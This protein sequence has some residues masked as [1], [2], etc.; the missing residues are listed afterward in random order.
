MTVKFRTKAGLAA[1]GLAVL[2]GGAVTASSMMDATWLKTR[3]IQ[4]A[5]QKTGRQL[6][7]RTLHVWLLP[8]PWMQAEGVSLAGRPGDTAAQ[9]FTAKEIR[10][11]LSL[12]ALF[13]HKIVLDDVY[14]MHPSLSL[15]HQKGSPANW[16]FEPAPVSTSAGGPSSGPHAT[17]NVALSTLHVENGHLVWDDEVSHLSGETDLDRAD[18]S[19]LTGSSVSSHIRGHHDSGAFDLTTTTGAWFPG[20][21]SSW[22]LHILAK[23]SEDK[24]QSGEVRVDGM[25]SGA[26]RDPSWDLQITG[27]IHH[28]TDLEAVFPKAGLP[29]ADDVSLQAAIA[30][31]PH[32]PQIRMLHLHAGDTDLHQLLRGLHADT[33][34]MDA[35]QPGDPLTVSLDGGLNGQPLVLRGTFGTADQTVQAARSG[36]SASLP[37]HLT[38]AD[39]PSSVSVAGT[40]GGQKSDLEIHGALPSFSSDPELPAA[41]GLKV[42]GHVSGQMPFSLFTQQDP[43]VWIRAVQGTLDVSAARV[44]WRSVAWTD[45]SAHI[46]SDGGK[47]TADPIRAKGTGPTAGMPQAG[48][49]TYD[50]SGD[51]PRIS[52]TAAPVVLPAEI[53]ENIAGIPALASGSLQFVGSVATDGDDMAAWKRSAGGH[54]GVSMVG[55]RVSGQ[56]LSAIIG[57]SVPMRGTLGL[58]CFGV[59][60]NIAD[61]R[62][63]LDRLGLEADQLSLSGHGSVGLSSG[64]LDLHLTPYIGF[65]GAGASSPVGVG[66]TI[67][68]PQPHLEPGSDGR[69]ALQI[70]G[71]APQGD[72]CPDLLSASREGTGGPAAAP[73]AEGKMHG[74]MNMLRGLIR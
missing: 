6:Q 16:E 57:R 72:P 64:A 51:T 44:T 34:T 7:I 54:L 42:D 71:N 52:V 15:E 66:G 53:V 4:A 61:N 69:F 46:V 38:L 48:H 8:Y 25:L 58:R 67:S 56:A 1:G 33:V 28:L 68:S 3:L 47:L 32:A 70:G 59:H 45:A 73:P 12:S 41:Q 10:G 17:W 60:M 62:A 50:V 9:M 36:V 63:A 31:T 23:L 11:R 18:I 13:S 2:L 74:L 27:N 30:G 29:D 43:D 5:E 40:I 55:G 24:R 26:L 20:P 14:V 65:G 49:F 21:V 35:A 39:G 19:G 22:P 37:V